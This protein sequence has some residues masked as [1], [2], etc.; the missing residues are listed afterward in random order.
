VA[1]RQL[2][3]GAGQA[4]RSIDVYSQGSGFHFD[5]DFR[6]NHAI[7][8]PWLDGAGTKLSYCNGEIQA[9]SSNITLY[10]V[11][12]YEKPLCIAQTLHQ[13]VA[14]QAETEKGVG[15]SRRASSV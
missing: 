15:E 1:G 3:L 5:A 8:Y 9:A 2:E 4:S 12:C 11:D 13:W 14:F 7:S 10:I 6:L